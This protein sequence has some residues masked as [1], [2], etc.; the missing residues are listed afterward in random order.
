MNPSR[1]LLRVASRATASSRL[2]ITKPRKILLLII[3]ES[4]EPGIAAQATPHDGPVTAET[5][6][7]RSAELTPADLAF[8]ARLGFRFKDNSIL[9]Q[10]LTH[11]SFDS[12]RTP[13][14][15]RLSWL[16]RH[17][18]GLYVGE[19]FYAKYPNLPTAA[20]EN[21]CTIHFGDYALG[22]IGKEL[23]LPFVLRWNS[24]QGPSSDAGLDLVTGKAVTAIVGALYENEGAA[25]A[26]RFIHAFLLS[27]S[28]DVTTAMKFEKPRTMLTMLAR[29]KEMEYPVA[30]LLK[31]TGRLTN[32][33]VFIVGMFSDFKKIG[34]GF[35]SSL[36]MAEHRACKDALIRYFM[37]EIKDYELP[38]DIP[39]LPSEEEITFFRA[40]EATPATTETA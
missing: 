11:P 7:Q 20:L 2:A 26:K 14:N 9:A 17:V 10:I 8:S 37:K 3:R 34:E 12:D 36:K 15:S 29:K 19:Y 1:S 31:E 40:K 4:I 39:N 21:L 35:G 5:S 27:R 22:Q 28:F 25:A 32:S 13:N 24:V 23:G 18:L 38:S 30:R 33:P 6:V 16:G